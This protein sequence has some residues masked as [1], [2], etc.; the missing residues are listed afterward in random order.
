MSA[1]V[2]LTALRVG[3]RVQDTLLVF[4]VDIRST[5]SGDPYTTLALGNRT[6]RLP[7]EPF[8][9]E[10]KAEVEGIRPG[11]VVQVIG[12]VTTWRDRRQLRVTSL[13]LL[14][15]GAF[16]LAALLPSAGPVDRYWETL[17]A[18]RREIRKP[19]LRK[20][21]DLFYED[22]DFRRRYEQ[23]PAAVRGH[24]AE[25]GGLLKHTTE[26]A[27]IART[28]ARVSGADPELT[29]AGVLLHDIGKLDSYRWDGMFEYTDVGR[30]LGH[31]ALGALIFERRLAEETEPPCTPLERDILLHIVLS[32]HGRLEFG[33][34]VPPMIMEAEIVH[35]ADNASART[36]SFGDILRDPE[37][38]GDGAVSAPMW[39]LDRR[40]VFRGT[41]DWGG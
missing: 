14:P 33:S 30:L 41:S 26:V 25:L 5:P 6:G 8:W 31:V 7:T 17:D 15:E 13:R 9:I 4:D 18:W 27:A 12:E 3:D 22:P 37:A 28:I 40:R 34:P 23:C 2:N 24:H 20:V 39:Q 19:R 38:F 35:W 36:A 10:R 11:H 16:D 29:L 1:P 32:H 21:V